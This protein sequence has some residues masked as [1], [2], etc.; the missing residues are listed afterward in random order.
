M[1]HFAF[2]RVII[3]VFILLLCNRAATQ[4]KFPLFGSYMPSDIQLKECDF[5]K[6]A[7][8]VYLL[9]KGLSYF[10][11]D[12]QLITE[13]RFRIKILKE[14]GISRGNIRIPFYSNDGFEQIHYIEAVV[15]TPEE[16]GSVKISAL[17]KNNIYSRQLTQLRSEISFALPNVKVGSII[18]YKYTSIMKSY[19]GLEKWNFQS[20]IPVLISA[21]ELSPLPNS[22]FRY[23]LYKKEAIPVIIKPDN[24]AGKV[25]FEMNNIPGI[26]EEVFST[27]PV[28]YYQR[29]EFQ[30]SS[31]TNNMG[32]RN[33]T[34]TWEM[35]TKELLDERMFGSQVKKDFS[36]ND[37]IKQ[38]PADKTP[39]EKMNFIYNYVRNEIAW[40][41]IYSKYSEKVKDV[42]EKKK[43]NSG[44]INLLL[45][46]LLRSAGLKAYPILVSERG[47]GRVD[48][49]SSF[50]D[51]FSNVHAYVEIDGN[52]YL[53][54]GTDK[55]TPYFM[56]PTQLL[57][58]VGYIVDKQRSRFIRF[59]GLKHKDRDF[60]YIMGKINPD[61]SVECQAT[62]T[63][64]EYAK[65]SKQQRYL[66][67]KDAYRNA[68]LKSYPHFRIDSF[69]VEGTKNDSSNLVHSV[70]FN[71]E[72]KKSGG[73]YML[74]YNLFTGFDEN[75]FVTQHRFTDID[76]GSLYIGTF[77]S[78]ITIPDSWKPEKLPANTALY[79]P[80]RSI[81]CKR[82]IEKNGN[83][84]KI[85]ILVSINKESY[86]AGD[87]DAIRAFFKDMIALLD[88]PILF[89]VK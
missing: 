8:A 54:D 39:I 75:P 56:I 33:F 63:N 77:S 22:A 86:P 73:Y 53:L 47:H 67:N 28:D 2:F 35:L 10:N 57:N 69:S 13:R 44:D 85:Q 71:Y 45:V 88:E 23:R 19:A 62:I 16:G 31:Y 64:F 9:D 42:L 55:Q 26:R 84:L 80:D 81:S 4:S 24:T 68:L 60:A 59:S 43:G 87:Y 61:G 34:N 76:F 18:D 1:K 58:T 5:D 50:L 30:M 52:E 15:I 36:G 38:I 11:E 29:V 70:K 37:L 89:P 82:M 46:A 51:Q 20:D 17:D 65:L 7:D 21:Y 74:N 79:S 40:N 48:T 66:D 32:K 27:S 3:S 41:N 14:K 12:F 83:E 49:T 78:T 6:S 25:Y 72:L